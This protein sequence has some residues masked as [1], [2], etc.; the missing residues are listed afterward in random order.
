[1]PDIEMRLGKDMLVLSAPI[2]AAL[3]R[4]GVNSEDLEF[5]NLVEPDSVRDI[6][7]LELVAGAQCLVLGTKHM[8]PAQLAAHGMEDRARE[9]VIALFT[10]AAQVR[11]QHILVELANCGLPLDASSKDSLN[12]H[13]AQYA[14]SARYFES[15]TFDAYYLQGFED[16]V[17]LKCALM[18]IRQASDRPIFASV[19]V[20]DNGM[21]TKRGSLEEAAAIMEEYGATVAGIC[22]VHDIDTTVSLTKRLCEACSL[23][24][25][26]EFDVIERNEK[27]GRATKENPSYCADC[28]VEAATKARRAGAQFLRAVGK[29]SPAY[30]GALV[31]ASMG[32]DCIERTH[33]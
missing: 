20:Q 4:Y 32:F 31:A 30:T 26:V 12:E 29:A 21:L 1:M 22:S 11:P 24:T 7:R 15:E 23:P 9:L 25:L 13:R 27:Q 10:V 28:M 19:R 17:A 18:G 14:Q 2:D 5:M 3:E 16:T 6:M 8:T 33:E